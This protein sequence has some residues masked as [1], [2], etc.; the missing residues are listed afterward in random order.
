MKVFLLLVIGVIVG[1]LSFRYYDDYNHP[2][3]VEVREKIQEEKNRILSEERQAEIDAEF[4]NPTMVSH[5][6]DGRKVEQ[7]VHVVNNCSYA[8]KHVIYVVEGSTTV[9]NNFTTSRSETVGKVRN[10]YYDN[11]VVVSTVK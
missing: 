10:T 3:K 8:C 2:E 4:S 5:L 11:N 9:S 7:F 1:C 6:S